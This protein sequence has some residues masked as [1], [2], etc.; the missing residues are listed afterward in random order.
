MHH[1]KLEKK[2]TAYIEKKG[3]INDGA[4][5]IIGL[6]GGPDSVFLMHFL[7]TI[8]EAK[9]LSLIA[10]HLDHG[11]RAESANDAQ[12]CKELACKY[13]I[14]FIGK[15]IADLDLSVKFNASK[16]EIGRK[17]RR[18]FFESV[19]KEHNASAI[20]LA[21]HADDQMETF[22]I[23]MMRGASLTGLVGMK[24]QD[25]MYIRP[26][27]EIKKAVI[28]AYLHENKINYLIDASNQSDSYL[29]NRIRNTAIPGLQSVDSRFDQNFS[30]THAN[31]VQT[32]EFLQELAHQTLRTICDESGSLA[33][34][35]LLA[36]HPAI[37]H[38][39]V[40]NWLVAHK[41][42]FT[43]SQGLLDEIIRFLEKPGNGHH[44]FYDKWTIHKNGNFASIIFA[45]V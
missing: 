42:P 39:V 2:I 37:C 4:R 36:L 15:T 21:H 10:A 32:E 25:G 30:T 19:A 43:P 31:L 40:I 16:E 24:A 34:D 1:T 33:V 20:A 17:A 45:N 27:L 26:L 41:V 22:F 13:S 11:W 9:K 18:T 29:R 5:L 44:I 23:R 6:S 38:R 28:L 7:A 8:R 12:F 14:P 3:L 35:Q